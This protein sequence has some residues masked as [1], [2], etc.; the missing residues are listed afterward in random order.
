MAGGWR[1]PLQ[2]I[3]LCKIILSTCRGSVMIRR[4]LRTKPDIVISIVNVEEIRCL[5][6]HDPSMIQHYYFILD[7]PKNLQYYLERRSSNCQLRF[8]VASSSSSSSNI[9]YYFFIFFSLS[10][11]LFSNR[12]FFLSSFSFS[13]IT[14][15][16]L[17]LS[18]IS[19]LTS[20]SSPFSS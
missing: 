11:L 6:R 12:A 10:A 8:V 13:T 17:A 20:V 14:F 18:T 7:R 4:R 15:A 2:K 5:T 9:C 16:L 3:S 19:F 1:R